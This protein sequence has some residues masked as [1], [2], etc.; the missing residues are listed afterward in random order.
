ME[1]RAYGNR[2]ALECANTGLI[3]ARVEK[4][5]KEHEGNIETKGL[6]RQGSCRKREECGRGTALLVR[7]DTII[8]VN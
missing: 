8:I 5:A 6:G 2:W 1:R 4:S 7:A 3:S